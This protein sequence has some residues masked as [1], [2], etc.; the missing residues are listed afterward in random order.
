M[1][2][3]N[4]EII[5]KQ[6]EFIQHALKVLSQKPVLSTGFQTSPQKSCWK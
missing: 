4:L 1:R 3:S 2:G 5:E 6:L